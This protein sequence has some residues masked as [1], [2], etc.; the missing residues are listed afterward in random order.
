[1][2]IS[3][4]YAI[5]NQWIRHPECKTLDDWER[6]QFISP[7]AID[8]TLDKVFTLNTD[9]TP[10]VCETVKK[11][12]SLYELDPINNSI[13]RRWKL[14]GGRVYDGMSNMYVEVPE[15][16]VAILYTRSSFTRNGVFLTSGIYDSGFK[17]AVGFT[18]FTVG[19]P[20]E[21]GEGV[22]IGQIAF[23]EASSAKM[24]AGGWNHKEG[25]HWATPQPDPKQEKVESA[26]QRVPEQLEQP[27]GSNPNKSEFANELEES[28]KSTSGQGTKQAGTKNFI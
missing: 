28:H 26:T 24:Y 10:Y 21:I 27:I 23:V 16:V 3:P 25:S 19:G 15:N 1:M 5:E 4:Q 11:M 6:H 12:R 14:E 7:N 9:D 18:I 2:F 20:I 17:G 8:F 13:E 22:R